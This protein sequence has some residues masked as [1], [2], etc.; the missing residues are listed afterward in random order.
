MEKSDKIELLVE[1]ENADR[2]EAGQF[3]RELREY[4]L[5]TDSS[6]EAELRRSDQSLM[7]FGATLALLLAAPSVIAVA[8]GIQAFLGR[9]QA[10]SI[11]IT[12]QG[13]SVVVEN[14]TARQASDLASSLM[15][16]FESKGQ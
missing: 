8:K 4:I 1:F 12:G 15:R 5:D 14:L 10:A 16:S 2:A 11:R 13:G 6:V 3:A 7:D 9:Y